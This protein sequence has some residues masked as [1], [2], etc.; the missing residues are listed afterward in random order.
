M[1]QV[2]FCPY[3]KRVAIGNDI[4]LKSSY[5]KFYFIYIF[6]WTTW[7]FMNATF[8]VMSKS[9]CE[10]NKSDHTQMDGPVI[11][12]WFQV[13]PTL[14]EPLVWIG[15]VKNLLAESYKAIVHKVFR[16]QLNGNLINSENNFQS[17]RESANQQLAVQCYCPGGRDYFYSRDRSWNVNNHYAGRQMS[18]ALHKRHR[19]LWR[20]SIPVF[21]GTFDLISETQHFIHP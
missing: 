21:T 3:R 4:I 13:I 19:T 15:D 20:S 18:F 8:H 1:K 11:E 9:S 16:H 14:C 6:F 5:R 12:Q 2:S 17:E 7:I 10:G